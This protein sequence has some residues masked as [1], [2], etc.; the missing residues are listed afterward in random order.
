[1]KLPLKWE[2]PGGKIRAGE[3]PGD[4]LKREIREEL[5]LEVE[6]AYELF[7]KTHHYPDF[8]VTLYPFICKAETSRFA[9]AEHAEAIWLPPDELCHLDW[10]GADVPVLDAYLASL[11]RRS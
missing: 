5:N 10:A 4:C 11:E 8:V 9:L 7:P 6:I 1:M 3:A 2:F